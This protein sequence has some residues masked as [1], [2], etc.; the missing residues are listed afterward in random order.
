MTDDFRNDSLTDILGDDAAGSDKPYNSVMTD[1][2]LE[3]YLLE[4][5]NDPVVSAATDLE[6]TTVTDLKELDIFFSTQDNSLTSHK[7]ATSVIPNDVRSIYEFT[8]KNEVITGNQQQAAPEF[9]PYENLQDADAVGVEPEYEHRDFRPIRRRRNYRTGCMGGVLFFLFV[10][11][12]SIILVVLGWMAANDV[13]ALTK[14]EM[15]AE[16]TLPEDIFTDTKVEITDEEGNVTTDTIVTADINYVADMLKQA[17]IIEYKFLFK[18]FAKFSD[19]DKKIDPGTYV[20]STSYDYRAIVTK[21]QTGSGASDTTLVTI[22]EGKT[23][24]QTFELLDKAG[25]CSVEELI[26]SATYTDFKYEFLNPTTLGDENRLEGYLFPDTYEFWLDSSPDNV[27]T[28]FLENFNAKF[29]KEMYARANEM[30]MTVH[31]IVTLA[32]LIEMEAGNDEERPI[33]ASVIYNRLGSDFYPY[34]QIDAT[35]QYILDERKAELTE[36]DLAIDNPYNTYFY[37]GLP[38]GPIANPGLAS[39][40]SALYPEDTE[41]YFYALNKQGTHNFFTDY[42]SAEAF[43]NSDEY[44][45]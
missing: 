23:L 25:V 6:K 9:N 12:V 7:D 24:I 13:L 1:E 31:E 3:R 18:L 30:D 27:I 39:I 38:P 35:I 45:G 8:E 14:S 20:L 4:L 11:C 10:L 32:S 42:E 16:I 33:I 40:E 26:E 34:L 29:K 43:T 17:G 5:D 2:E 21:L 22:P 41:Y 36:T 28:K 19:A 44:G 37:P 15:T